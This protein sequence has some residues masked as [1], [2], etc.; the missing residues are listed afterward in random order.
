M[1]IDEKT[2]RAPKPFNFRWRVE[3]LEAKPEGKDSGMEC[4]KNETMVFMGELNA[5]GV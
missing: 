5:S 3:R 2:T 4:W 1:G